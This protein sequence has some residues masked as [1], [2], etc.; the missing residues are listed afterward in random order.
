MRLLQVEEHG[1]FSLTGNIPDM[2]SPYA[3]LSHTWGDEGEE[4]SF[5]DLIDGSGKTKAGYRKLRFCAKQAARDGLHHFW[6]DTLLKVTSRDASLRTNFSFCTSA[7][8]L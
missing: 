2:T 4:V 7:D 3:I 8:L 5:K 6:V 1:G